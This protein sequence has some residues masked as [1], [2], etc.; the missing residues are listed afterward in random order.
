MEMSE[1]KDDIVGNMVGGAVLLG[2]A[3][4]SL[5]HLIAHLPPP[6]PTLCGG[7]AL[8]TMPLHRG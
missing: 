8:V 1:G 2:L 5:V 6:V 7:A 4:P 3:D